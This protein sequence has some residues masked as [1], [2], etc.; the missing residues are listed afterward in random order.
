MN[1]SEITHIDSDSASLLCALFG[2]VNGVIALAIGYIFLP[3]SGGLLGTILFFALAVIIGGISGSIAGL[4]I[5]EIYNLLS[6]QVGGLKVTVQSVNPEQS[7]E[8][9]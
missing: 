3:S 2:S 6:D 1:E 5:A 7:R 4:A 9:E 8:M